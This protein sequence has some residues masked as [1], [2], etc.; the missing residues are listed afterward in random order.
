MNAY[1]GFA[2]P[3]GFGVIGDGTANPDLTET[4]KLISIL[5][6][7]LNMP[8]LD[9]TVGNPYVNPHVNRPADTLPYEHTEHSLVGISRVA[10][11]T[12]ELQKEF[13]ELPIVASAMTYLRQFSPNY[14]AAM[15]K[16]GSC[17]IAGFGRMAF[18]YPDFARDIL[19][20][21]EINADKCC[22]TCGNCSLLMRNNSSTGCVIRDRETYYPLY[23]KFVL[24]EE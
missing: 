10:A 1:D 17:A 9:V 13:P 2:Y 22:I 12:T 4:K 21:G 19:E 7:E 5:Y 16:N 6:N 8:L 3:N 15:I 23:K 24:K 11:I 20:T 14:A 18:A